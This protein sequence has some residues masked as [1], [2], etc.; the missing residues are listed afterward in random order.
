MRIARP[1]RRDLQIAGTLIGAL[2]P[3][4]LYMSHYLG[5]EMLAGAFAGL[6][7]LLALRLNREPAGADRSRLMVPI[8]LTLGLAILT[9]ASAL[10]LAVPLTLLVAYCLFA[11]GRKNLAVRAMKAY[12]AVFGAAALMSGWF[13]LR[14]LYYLGRPF[15]GGWEPERGM[16]WWQD[17]GY[18]TP[19]DFLRF[20]DALFY[21]VYSSLSSIWNGLYAS[22]WMD[23]TLGS[24]V[25]R[26]EA[27]EWNY[28]FLLSSV[29]LGLVPSL[30]I[31]AGLV[32]TVAAPRKHM[33]TGHLFAVLCIAIYI[34]VIL[35]LCL[36]VPFFSPIK[37]S[38]TVGLTPC[39]A[40]LATAGVDLASKWR[41]SRYVLHGLL[42]AWAFAAYAGYFIL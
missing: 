35:N 32:R 20:G 38:Y 24:I 26:V 12:A 25:N 7:I 8:G 13:F 4:N 14:N 3:M 19:G 21:P 40:L 36:H 5:N 1:D 41:G 39:Y 31:A 34:A 27:P 11:P 6:C 30:L 28:G 10:V 9:K 29:W 33:G 37:A 2:L 16:I 17:P 22:F 23:S 15:F 42:A 18:R